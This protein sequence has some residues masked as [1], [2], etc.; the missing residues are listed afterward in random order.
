MSNNICVIGGCGHVG[1]PLAIMFASKGFVVNIYDLDE[2]KIDLINKSIMPFMD[3]GM[4]E[5]LIKV[6]ESGM[7]AATSNPIIISKSAFVII[8]IG[9]PVDEH[10]NPNVK[11]MISFFEKIKPHLND[12]Q[13]LILRST[14]FPGT[15]EIVKNYLIK[16][17][18]KSRLAFCPERLIQ[19]KSLEELPILPQ[20]I[21][22]FDE[23]TIEIVSNLFKT[24]VEEIIVL[25]PMEAEMAK[26]FTNAWR[27]I[28]F[29]IANQ[30]YMIAEDNNVDFYKILEAIKY[31]YPRAKDF[32][33]A[34][35]AAG[36]CL[37]KDT[38]QLSSFTNNKFFLGH[39]AMLINEG[40][41]NYIVES[42][43]KTINLKNKVVG[44]LGMAFKGESD[45]IRESLAFKLKKILEIN[46]DK[47]ICNDPYINDPTFL[48]IE[49]TI[50][51]SDILIIAAPHKIYKTEIKTEKFKDKIIIDIWNLVK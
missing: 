46:C 29:A 43:K 32:P 19:G 37:F 9:T 15:T 40:L 17:N 44:I 45:D 49:D 13:T 42:L 21:S 6:R 16:N 50:R 35:F 22:S 3:T 18:I 39:S 38:M 4:D 47:V 5:L 31:K 11:L 48:S 30:F 10:L 14:V 26:L 8:V 20:I 27:Y 33:K 7:L 23:T 25:N 28:Q 24:I 2:K 34:G 1:L 36:P 51:C 12:E 41:P